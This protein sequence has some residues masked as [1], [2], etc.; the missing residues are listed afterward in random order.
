MGFSP[1]A[2]L[3]SILFGGSVISR[4]VSR[5]RSSTQPSVCDN[6]G[7][8]NEPPVC[9]DGNPTGERRDVMARSASDPAALTSSG[10][11]ASSLPYQVDVL[12]DYTDDLEAGP[13]PS[14]ADS[15]DSDNLSHSADEAALQ[16]FPQPANE[17]QEAVEQLP[18]PAETDPLWRYPRLAD[19][20][21]KSVFAKV[22]QVSGRQ[23]LCGQLA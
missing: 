21:C 19:P 18:V 6:D 1:K 20:A 4:H 22:L 10:T 11:Q 15:S 17:S 12:D 9:E 3:V 2:R 14:T 8:P 16:H 7:P 13:V 23:P 5:V